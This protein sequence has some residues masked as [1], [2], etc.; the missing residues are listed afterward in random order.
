MDVA[1]R[2]Y[3]TIRRGRA[4]WT[5]R[6]R[7]R[8]P[9]DHS[10]R[11]VSKRCSLPVRCKVSLLGIILPIGLIIIPL[12]VV[13]ITGLGSRS[14]LLSTTP[15]ILALALRSSSSALRTTPDR[16][17]APER[18]HD[19]GVGLPCDF[20]G[21]RNRENGSCIQDHLVVCACNSSRS[22]LNARDPKTSR[23]VNVISLTGSN[24]ISVSESL[25]S[26]SSSCA[27]AV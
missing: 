20:T 7:A 8:Q 23:G 6:K 26:T 15:R 5:P 27:F 2:E 3:L 14:T 18:G 4:L 11:L 1:D 25:T 12:R 19:D 24:I 16:A 9:R 10:V 22:S 21:V 13:A 17:L